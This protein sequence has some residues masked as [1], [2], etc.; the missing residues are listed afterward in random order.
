MT[1]RPSTRQSIAHLVGELQVMVKKHAY[2]GVFTVSFV[3]LAFVSW[4]PPPSRGQDPAPSNTSPP[5]TNATSP[6]T[7]QPTQRAGSVPDYIRPQAHQPQR[8]RS[9]IHHYPYPYPGAYHND[10]TAGF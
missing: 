9:I 3:G 7:N 5:G 1:L 10:D 4:A 8:R 6:A 2:V